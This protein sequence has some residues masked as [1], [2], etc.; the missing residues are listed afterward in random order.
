MA[1]EKAAKI[2]WKREA[3]FTQEEIAAMPEGQAWGWIRVHDR[4]LRDRKA[5]A[6]LPQICFTGFKVSEKEKLTQLANQI[7]LEVKEPVTKNLTILVIGDNAGPSKVAKAKAQ[8]CT[9]F[10]KDDFMDYLRRIK[11]DE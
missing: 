5:Q 4:N 11:K 1:S 2:L 6:K 10:T 9:I 8:D 3:P 7:G